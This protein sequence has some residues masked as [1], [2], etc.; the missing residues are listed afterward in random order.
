MART[1]KYTVRLVSAWSFA[2]MLVRAR[3]RRQ[4][5]D[6]QR[7]RARASPGRSIRARETH[8]RC[9]DRGAV[10]ARSGR[11]QHRRQ[12]PRDR[13]PPHFI[14]QGIAVDQIIA[15]HLATRSAE[16]V[17]RAR[18]DGNPRLPSRDATHRS[19]RF[20]RKGRPRLVLV[21]IRRQRVGP[22]RRDEVALSRPRRRRNR[23]VS[24]RLMNHECSESFCLEREQ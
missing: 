4:R 18:R 19:R 15:S 24:F 16:D 11:A 8:D 13:S 12:P 6:V 5:L 10:Q 9:G 23:A 17:H 21:R 7:T 20:R 14:A 22:E 2:V 1:R 3:G